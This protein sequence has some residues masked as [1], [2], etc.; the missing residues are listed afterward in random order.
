MGR[1]KTLDK[2]LYVCYSCGSDKSATN[3]NGV[4]NWF[5]NLPTPFVLCYRCYCHLIK[6]VNEAKR[7]CRPLYHGRIRRF[8]LLFKGKMIYLE[9]NPRTGICSRCK[10]TGHTEMHHTRYD[11]TDPLA[12]TIELCTSCHCKE[13]WKLGQYSHRPEMIRDRLSGRFVAL[14]Q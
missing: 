6:D 1:P 7:H 11:S 12:N 3:S 14:S 9:H 10:K 2:R 13:S 8:H 5:L 4:S